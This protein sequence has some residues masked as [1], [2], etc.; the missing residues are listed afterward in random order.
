MCLI[1]LFLETKYRTMTNAIKRTAT[2]AIAITMI[3]LSG[4]FNKVRV[5]MTY[6][7][8]YAKL[9]TM[10]ENALFVKYK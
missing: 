5:S 1:S 9:K 10:R 4:K 3:F 6:I 8:H 7:I 2:A